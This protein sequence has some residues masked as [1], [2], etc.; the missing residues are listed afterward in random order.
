MNAILMNMINL[1]TRIIPSS[2]VGVFRGI[3]E[4]ILSHQVGSMR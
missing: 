4:G 3:M 1:S 2:F